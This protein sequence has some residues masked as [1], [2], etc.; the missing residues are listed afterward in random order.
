METMMK[1][2]A[3]ALGMVV[4]A[5]A[6]LAQN[7]PSFDCTKA[8][9]EI[10]KTICK[11]PDLAKVDRS[12][13]SAYS[14]LLA[15]LDDG[16]ARE[17]FRQDQLR[18][19]ANRNSGCVSGE[20]ELP[21]CLKQRY[22][23]R[24]ARIA[25]LGK[26]PYP[27]ISEQAIVKT[28][29][30]KATR[31]MIDA[32]YPQF[33]GP[34]ADFSNTNAYFFKATKESVNDVVPGSD[35]GPDLDQTWSLDQS[36]TL[37]RPTA[38]ALC[39]EMS[40]YAFSGGAHGYGGTAGTLV[41]LRTGRIV[42]PDEIFAEDQD[43]GKTLRALVTADLKKQFEEKPGFDDALEARHIDKLLAEPGHFVWQADK[44]EIVFNAYE[45]GPYAVGPYY[46]DIPYA[47]IK[48]LLRTDGPLGALR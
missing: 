47:R 43:W 20:L 25:E 24:L 44:L 23:S 45:I 15:K 27:F 33:D 35:V 37:H 30:I 6:A 11:T 26:G 34:S 21:E 13:A 4:A 39:V 46:V 14:S 2:F 41:D 36:F 31:Y 48:Q 42:R 17:H 1:T 29:K 8:S 28:G 5:S 12:L 40:G 32:A 19:I 16:P 38:N 22:D 10:E 18:W 9:T 7:G 3:T